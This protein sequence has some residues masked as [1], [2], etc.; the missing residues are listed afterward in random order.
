MVLK[1]LLCLLTVHRALSQSPGTTQAPGSLEP[2][3]YGDSLPMYGPAQRRSASAEINFLKEKLQ[4][5]VRQHD[6]VESQTTFL[7]GVYT[8]RFGEIAALGFGLLG[9]ATFTGSSASLVS[10]P[11]AMTL[12]INQTAHNTV[13]HRGT[14]RVCR[15]PHSIIRGEYH[16]YNASQSMFNSSGHIAAPADCMKVILSAGTEKNHNCSLSIG[17]SPAVASLIVLAVAQATAGA[18]LVVLS[19]AFAPLLARGHIQQRISRDDLELAILTEQI[20][21]RIAVLTAQ[22]D[23]DEDLTVSSTSFD[24]IKQSK[25]NFITI[26]NRTFPQYFYGRWQSISTES[27]LNNYFWRLVAAFTSRFTYQSDHLKQS[28]RQITIKPTYLTT[29]LE[30]TSI[31]GQILISTTSSNI[32]RFRFVL[33]PGV[34]SQLNPN[35]QNESMMTVDLIQVVGIYLGWEDEPTW[36]WYTFNETNDSLI[37]VTNNRVFI[38][39]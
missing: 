19:S 31:N 25:R 4:A 24:R 12:S 3:S 37:D 15:G 38:R 35:D 1:L 36:Q 10:L 14:C 26:R 5:A 30:T 39:Q 13:N 7:R 18:A 29:L 32:V 9:A 22:A 28:V 11:T 34:V 16:R 2:I 17:G 6:I 23:L 21:I 27:S 33:K 8:Q 20:S